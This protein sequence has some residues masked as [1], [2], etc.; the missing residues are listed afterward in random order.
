MSAKPRQI[1]V[2][3]DNR[4][5]IP[6]LFPKNL[7]WHPTRG[8]KG[9][10]VKVVEKSTKILTGDYCLGGYKSGAVIE[11]KGSLRELHQNLLT[12]DY[13]RFLSAIERLAE[14][15]F[16]YLLLDMTPGD[17]ATVSEY[18][19]DPSRVVDALMRI[20]AKYH[21][22]LLFAGNCKYPL[23]RRRLGEQCLRIMMGHRYLEV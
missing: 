10:L 22:R 1:T 15:Q 23:S 2:L 9:H 18:V 13:R 17:L 19:P 3:V 21:L 20:V 14:C 8:G 5:R 7:V 16:P 4:E 6:L 11:R 12:K